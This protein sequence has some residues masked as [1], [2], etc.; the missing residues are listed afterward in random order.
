MGDYKQ[1]VSEIESLKK[2]IAELR[3]GEDALRLLAENNGTPVTK[4]SAKLRRNLKGHFGKVYA[5]QWSAS[6]VHHLVSASQ[7]GKLLVWISIILSCILI[8]SW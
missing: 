7:D 5:V 8:V 1:M 4:L 2:Q 6:D 3:T